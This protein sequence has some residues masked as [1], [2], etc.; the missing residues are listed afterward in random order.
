M[1][2]WLICS[3]YGKNNGLDKTCSIWARLSLIARN[4]ASRSSGSFWSSTAVTVSPRS[5]ARRLRRVELIDGFGVP[6]HGQPN[7]RRKGLRQQFELFLR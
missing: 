1:A 5:V 4:A 6:Q 7:R 2:N 3:R